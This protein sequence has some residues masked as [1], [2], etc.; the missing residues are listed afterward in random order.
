MNYIGIVIV[1]TAYIMG[2]G[3]GCDTVKVRGALHLSTLRC[4]ATWLICFVSC[5]V[6]LP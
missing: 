5:R 6:F 1:D 3:S 2:L 4:L